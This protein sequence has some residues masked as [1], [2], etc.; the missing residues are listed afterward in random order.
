MNEGQYQRRVADAGPS[1]ADG[2]ADRGVVLRRGAASVSLA[3]GL[4]LVPRVEPELVGLGGQ[5]ALD[6][7]PA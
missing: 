3:T 1:I 2:G 4:D 7:V 6:V 5:L